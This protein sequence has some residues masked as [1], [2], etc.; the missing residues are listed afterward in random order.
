M[1][2][3]HFLQISAVLLNTAFF[4]RYINGSSETM[5]SAHTKFEVTKTEAEWKSILTP[6]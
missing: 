3:C 1:D 2:K 4:S 6:E 5:A